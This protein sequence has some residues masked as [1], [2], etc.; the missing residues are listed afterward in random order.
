LGSEA[1]KRTDRKSKAEISRQ[2]FD[3][4]FLIRQIRSVE[5]SKSATRLLQQVN[6]VFIPS[7]AAAY[8][9]PDREEVDTSLGKL[10]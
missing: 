9:N 7:V 1:L 3:L 6:P 8:D 5:L 2:V 10:C 4:F